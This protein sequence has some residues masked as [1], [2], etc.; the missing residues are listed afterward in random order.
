[1]L[2][3]TDHYDK[4][5]D[6]ALNQGHNTDGFDVSADNL[7]IEKREASHTMQLHLALMPFD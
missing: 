1:M 3:G 6:T 4:T 5:I 2:E 7:V